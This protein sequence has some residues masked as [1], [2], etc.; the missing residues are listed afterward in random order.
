MQLTILGPVIA[1]SGLLIGK[2]IARLA[3]EEIDIDLKCIRIFKLILATSIALFC[4]AY[5]SIY[6]NIVYVILGGV[7]GLL[8]A[9][10]GKPGI[11]IDYILLGLIAAA[12]LEFIGSMPMQLLIFSLIFLYGF[13]AGSIAKDNKALIVNAASFPLAFIISCFPIGI[14][15][16]FGFAAF[17][18]IFSKS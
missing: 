13:P 2:L 5:A 17:A 3:R 1:F 10:F 15:H 4:I 9:R 18:L 16:I 14:S 6:S 8:T 12:S 11:S 7:A